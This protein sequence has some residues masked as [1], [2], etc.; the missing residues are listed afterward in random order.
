MSGLL[1]SAC[2]G[3][4]GSPS[5][6]P[7]PTA[8]YQS[9]L[10]S[11]FGG[12][13][14]AGRASARTG[15]GPRPQDAHPD[16]NSRWRV[17]D[18][19]WTHREARGQGRPAVA[20]RYGVETGSRQRRRRRRYRRRPG[21]GRHRSSSQHLRP[22]QSGPALHPQLLWRLRRHAG[23]TAV[24]APALG[25]RLTLTDD[26]SAN[27]TVP[28]GF[29][30]LRQDRDR[31]VRQFRRQHH[32]RGTGQVEHRTQRRAAA[33]RAAEGL[34]VSRRSRS[35]R[36]SRPGLSRRGGGSLHRHVV[37][38]ARV[39]YEQT[40]TVQATL[41]P[42]GVIEM[43]YASGITL[44]DAIVGLSPGRTGDFRT[45]NLTDPGPTAGGPAAVGER[46]AA[47]SPARPRRA[48]DEV[49]QHASR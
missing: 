9:L 5:D 7:S 12:G 39:R 37:Q 31:C 27:S 43:V 20:E 45:V 41:L 44:R 19:L 17:L 21:Q 3:S 49:L 33:D 25:T 28:F 24:S 11:G 40:T 29:P 10:D 6:N 16:G 32:V 38:R 15:S 47:E 1:V 26:D 48:G 30:V 4:S 35:E 14:G 18:A 2:G 34:S 36:R 13:R 8:R 23:S 46:F 22:R 42:S